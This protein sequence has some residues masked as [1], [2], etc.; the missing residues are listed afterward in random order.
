MHKYYDVGWFL[1]IKKIAEEHHFEKAIYEYQNYLEKYPNDCCGYA[2]YADCLIRC[3]RLEEA[4]KVLD[5]VII[6]P[7]TP[8]ASKQDLIMM[9]LKLLSAT[10]RYQECYELFI[11][12]IDIFEDREIPHTE[13]LI[14]L[15]KKLN[16]L[17]DVD[18]SG[19]NYKIDQI[20]NYSEK[21][22]LDCIRNCRYVPIQENS[23][24]F[25]EDFLLEE[26]YYKL[27]NMLPIE[28]RMFDNIIE[29]SY[30]F[31]YENCGRVGSRRVDYLEVITLQ[32][33]NDIIMIYPYENKERI[34]CEDLTPIK[35]DVPKVKR[36]SQIEKF[37]Q[38]YNK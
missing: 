31:R 9:R 38:R 3:G 2:Y 25:N 7:S 8:L 14:F 21:R 33:S 35:E 18:Y 13:T 29:S 30:I 37:N 22:A 26:T 12:N 6:I 1:K 27:R 5:D 20:T 34:S 19:Y 24:V 4:E 28:G 17:S 23:A 15:K 16:L 11:E 36:L 32:N 10:G